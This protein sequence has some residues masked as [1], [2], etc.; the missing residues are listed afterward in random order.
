[1]KGYLKNILRFI[2]LPNCWISLFCATPAAAW[3]SA[4]L[5]NVSVTVDLASSGP[6]TVTTDARFVVEA[7]YFHGFDFAELPGAELDKSQ[8][9]AFQDDQRE[10]PV[11]FKRVRGKI[12]VLLADDKYVRG[13]G[14]TFRLVHKI[15]FVDV[16]ALRSQGGRTRFD[17]TPLVWDVG[18]DNMRVAVRLPESNGSAE[19]RPD[20][21]VS[22]DYV[23]TVTENQVSFIKFRPV[24]W[25]PMRIAAD[26]DAALISDLPV[27]ES[28]P[29]EPV[30]ATSAPATATVREPPSDGM[31]PLKAVMIFAVVCLLGWIV[32][33]LKARHICLAYRTVGIEPVFRLL[34]RTSLRVR[35]LLALFAVA[36]GSAVQIA[37]HAAAGIPLFITAAALFLVQTSTETQRLR[38][39]GV[40]REM[41]D[42]DIKA[43][44]ALHAAYRKSRSS[45]FDITTVK[46]TVLLLVLLGTLLLSVVAG[47]LR[48]TETAFLSL[49]D[50]ALLLIPAWFS[51]IRSELPVDTTI[52]GFGLLRKW[53]KSL[54]K[55]IGTKNEPADTRFFVR[56]DEAGPIEVRLRA[57]L[58]I[59]G[60][61]NIET[62]A[63][64]FTAGT[65]HRVRTVFVLRM[66]PGAPVT[67][68][69]AA[70]PHAAEHHLT[71]DLQEEIIVLRN[72]R[73][74][75]DTGLLPLRVALHRIGA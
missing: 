9:V 36:I 43:Y 40:W 28:E 31:P 73:G 33:V 13:G 61:R 7:G 39:G 14:I 17:W 23:S 70:C 30:E 8:A 46:G 25:Y 42:A 27:A 54:A 4:H 66:E 72:R 65:V 71:P 35:A 45:L 2:V 74:K 38:P 41:T 37:G 51:G 44:T 75:T 16:G 64:E 50:G 47:E 48:S 24:K 62:A 29:D 63:E 10:Y 22:K 56:E 11:T 34:Q 68:K 3:T 21:A 55:L 58:P 32:S 19:I 6:S 59:E 18:L 69:L 67:R 52:E 15:D 57:H 1:M 12:R 26:F 60:L 53:R 5:F 49:V 20:D